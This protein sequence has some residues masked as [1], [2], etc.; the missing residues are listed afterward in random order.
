MSD[1][2]TVKHILK[3]NFKPMRCS[4]FWEYENH[5]SNLEDIKLRSSSIQYVLYKQLLVRSEKSS[6]RH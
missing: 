5:T 1:A 4:I 3:Q 2:K 6:F